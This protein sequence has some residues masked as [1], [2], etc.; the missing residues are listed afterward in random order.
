MPWTLPLN[1]DSGVFMSP[2][3]STQIRPIGSPLP[4]RPVGGGRHRAGAEAVVAAEDQRERAACPRL[5]S[6]LAVQRR[7]HRGDLADVL[8]ARVAGVARFRDRHVQV[9]LVDDRMAERGDLRVDAGDAQRRGTHV[10]AAP[11]LAEVERHADDVDR[12]RA[13]WPPQRLTDTDTPSPDGDTMADRMP[14]WVRMVVRKSP[15]SLALFT[16]LCATNTPPLS[17][18]GNTMSK[19][20]W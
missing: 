14:G 4:G 7:A 10:D 18:R 11:A 15:I 3:A 12:A 6:G 9:A 2:C 20:R 19:N 1:D 17:R 8:L 16:T 13:A 5:S